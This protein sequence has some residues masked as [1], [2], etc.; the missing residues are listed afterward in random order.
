MLILGQ[1]GMRQNSKRSDT[2]GEKM[3]V[4]GITGGVGSGKS[5]ITKILKEQ[6]HAYLISTDQVAHMLMQKDKISYKL[7]VEQ[8]GQSILNENKEIDRALLGL[9]VYQDSS[10]LVLLNSLTHPY[11]MEYVCELIKI[12]RAEKI[13]LVCVETALP[14]EA[15]LKDFCDEIWYISAPESVRRERLKKDRKYSEQKIDNIFKNQ[16]SDKDYRIAS[17]HTLNNDC[18]KEIISKQ[19]EILLEK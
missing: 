17:T 19:I 9:I 11:V 3:K 5:T 12:K 18:S 6:Y 1:I 13:E 15:G 10:K 2:I 8:F 7:I 16:I 14:I 4:I